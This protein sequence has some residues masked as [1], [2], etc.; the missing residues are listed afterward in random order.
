VA[1]GR[2]AVRD[3]SV[4]LSPNYEFVRAEQKASLLTVPGVLSIAGSG[5]RAAAAVAE[6]QR[7][8]SMGA[9]ER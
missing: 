9:A 6:R 8:K 5:L 4:A 2:S 1:T 7:F 3:M